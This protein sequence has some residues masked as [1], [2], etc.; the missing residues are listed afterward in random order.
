[1]NSRVIAFKILKPIGIS[2]HLKAE[3][4][5][6]TSMISSYAPYFDSDNNIIT[7]I[8]CS[9]IK[10]NFCKI[11]IN[12]INTRDD[13]SL[14]SNKEIFFDKNRLPEVEQDEYYIVDLIG[15]GIKYHDT[16][17]GH[18]KSV[19]NFGAGDLLNVQ[20][21]DKSEYYV[22]FSK[23]CFPSQ[24]NNNLFISDFGYDYYIKLKSE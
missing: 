23:D 8:T 12:E 21:L 10:N 3:F 22:P 7:I 13:A 15:M 9:V 16:E 5:I 17:I 19:D 20:L 1:M 24:D 18:V 14:F 11:R 4:F 6:D 2:G